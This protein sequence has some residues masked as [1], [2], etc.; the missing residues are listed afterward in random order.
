[1]PDRKIRFPAGPEVAKS[2][3]DGRDMIYR[4]LGEG[5]DALFSKLEDGSWRLS[6]FHAA[7]HGKVYENR[8]WIH[9]NGFS[10]TFDVWGKRDGLEVSLGYDPQTGLLKHMGIDQFSRS[11]GLACVSVDSPGSIEDSTAGVPVRLNS[12]P[13]IG[14]LL[15]GDSTFQIGDHNSGFEVGPDIADVSRMLLVGW[16]NGAVTDEI[17]FKKKVE[18]AKVVP[19]LFGALAANPALP[20]GDVDDALKQDN[21][22]KKGGMEWKQRIKPPEDWWMPRPRTKLFWTLPN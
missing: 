6:V 12:W 2:S 1:M 10:G 21:L 14:E 17:S 11:R 13:T 20:Y 3:L 15:E 9:D 8:D 7:N 5:K 16:E 4:V 22:L 18:R 19:E